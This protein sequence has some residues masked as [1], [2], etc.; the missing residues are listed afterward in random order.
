MTEAAEQIPTLEPEASKDQPAPVREQL[1]HIRCRLIG[2]TGK[3]GTGKDEVANIVSNLTGAKRRSFADPIKRSL[4]HM[5][6]FPAGAW[7]DRNWKEK[8]LPMV[9]RSP[10]QLAQTLGTE[11]GRQ[12]VNE[13]IWVEAVMGKWQQDG[14][15]LTVI[16]DVRFANEAV[17][18]L[19]RGGLVLRVERD[20]EDVAAHASEVPIQDNLIHR[21]IDNNGSLSSLEGKVIAAMTAHVEQVKELLNANA[22]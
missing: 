21:T 4:D 2:I 5:F 18:I 22:Q 7:D 20:V 11:W 16:P 3:A 9:G 10:R 17:A 15:P 19:N 6:G 8:S 12:M 14:Y 1:E 13:N